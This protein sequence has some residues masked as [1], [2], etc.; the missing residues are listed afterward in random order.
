MKI[1]RRSSSKRLRLPFWLGGLLVML[2][3]TSSASCVNPS[4]T[5]EGSG[6]TVATTVGT[7]GSRGTG[8][9]NVV[10]VIT[11]PD[12]AA[13]L[14]TG[15]YCGDGVVLHNEQCDDGNTVG[16]DGCSRICQIEANYTCP[17]QGGP[18]VNQAVCGNG[19]LTSNEE[20]DDGNSIS[21]DGCSADCKKVEAGF[22]CR[23]PGKPC[24]AVCGDGQVASIEQCDDGNTT[25]GDG[26]AAT[27]KVEPGYK[28]SGTPSICGKTVCGDKKLEGGEGCDDGNTIPFDGCSAECQIEPDCSAGACVSKCGDGLVLNEDCDDAN[29]ASG[30]G[31]SADCKLEPGWTCTQ[32]PMGD[33]MMVPVVYRDFRYHNPKEFEDGVTGQEAASKGIVEADLDKDGKPVF[34]GLTGG[35]VHITS[36]TTFAQWYRNTDGVNH[37]TGAKLALWNNG[38]GG[39]VNRYG[40]GGERWTVTTTA[41][42]CG[43]VGEE[44]RDIDANAP[45]PCTYRYQYQPEL[46]GGPT[47]L[48]D[49]Q[50]MEALGYT[51]VRCY[52]D[53]NTYKGTYSVKEV[54]GNPLFFPVD[55]DNFTPSTERSTAGIPST[56]DQLYD[57]S[58]SWPTEEQA[59]GVRKLHNFSFTSEVRYWFKYDSSKSYRLEFTGDDDV[60]VFINRKLAV[61]LGG[62]HIPVAGAITLDATAASKLGG[63]KSGNVYEVAVFQAERQTTGSTYKLTLSGFNTSISTCVPACGDGVAVANEECDNGAANDDTVYGGC[64]TKCKWGPFCGDGIVNGTEA[65]DNGKE[66][67]TKYGE[68]GC[69]LGC[70]KPHYCGDGIVDTDRAEECDLGPRNGVKLDTEHNPTDTDGQVYCKPD[71]TIPPTIVW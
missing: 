32:A 9:A 31:C 2:L 22:A 62:I 42:W 64:T 38:Q 65:C 43:T 23:V 57:A 21:G 19:S 52:K 30:D 50:K 63:L 15:P 67:G 46:D 53:G 44:L 61:D 47:Q 54:D 4:I 69:T 66:N 1:I 26:C 10:V 14:P 36:K 24:I 29:H 55:D 8:G 17:P 48:T 33:P 49:C 35:G 6:G 12:A 58:G 45:E 41:N 16:G 5:T 68:G 11:A 13:D 20:C 39:Y 56:D 51:L 25:A 28:C 40:E 37:A 71:C 18:C 34:T 27:C 7:G 3:A 60:W 70:T 59:T